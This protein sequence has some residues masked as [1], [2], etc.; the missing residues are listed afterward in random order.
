MVLVEDLKTD[1][2]TVGVSNFTTNLIENSSSN[3]FIRNYGDN[4][5]LQVFSGNRSVIFQGR[6]TTGSTLEIAQFNRDSISFNVSVSL[7]STSGIANEATGSFISS[8][9]KTVTVT[10]G[11]VTSINSF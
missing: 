2:V 3:F 8:D 1:K 9:H 10:K 5:Y 4:I 6:T 11:I 7:S